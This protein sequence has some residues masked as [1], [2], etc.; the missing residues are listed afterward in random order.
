MNN[1]KVEEIEEYDDE[2]SGDDY[3]EEIKN[4]RDSHTSSRSLPKR[5]KLIKTNGQ[6]PLN[7][8]N[9]AVKYILLDESLSG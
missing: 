4:I 3:G 7:D 1:I 5:R 8:S 2:C 6:S 9:K